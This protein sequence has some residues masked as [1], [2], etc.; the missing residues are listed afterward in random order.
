[1]KIAGTKVTFESIVKNARC[2]LSLEEI[3]AEVLARFK[4]QSKYM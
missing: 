4:G 3:K 2:P 1:M